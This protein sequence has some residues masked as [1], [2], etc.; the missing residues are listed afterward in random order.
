MFSHRS[1][2]PGTGLS[3][4]I[5]GVQQM[6][7]FFSRQLG[8]HLRLVAKHGAQMTLFGHGAFA[9]LFQQVMRG[10]APDPLCQDDAHRFGQYQA[11]GQIEVADHA[12]GVHFQ[13]LRHQQRLLQ[14]AW[15]PAA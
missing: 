9:T 2:D 14:A 15:C 12:P 13:P 3:E 8:C 7:E 10:V 5:S 1:L 11:L 6:I 4:V